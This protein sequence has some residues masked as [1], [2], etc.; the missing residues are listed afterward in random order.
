MIMREWL[1]RARLAWDETRHTALRAMRTTAPAAAPNAI[2]LE[3]RVLLSASP[4]PVVVDG[5]VADTDGTSDLLAPTN[6]DVE[7]AAVSSTDLA[8]PDDPRTAADGLALLD[9]LLGDV[10]RA[11][12]QDGLLCETVSVDSS[13]ADV[14]TG[15]SVV[16]PTDAPPSTPP[17]TDPLLQFT[18]Q[19]HVLGFGQSSIVVASPSHMLQVELVGA[20]LVDPVAVDPTVD[21]AAPG[22]AQPFSGVLYAGVWDGVSAVYDA[23]EGAILKSTYYVDAGLDGSPADQIRLHY[24]RTVSMDGQGNLVIAYDTGT[25]TDSA[26]V[27]WQDIGGQRRFVQV[28]YVLLGN[29]DVGFALGEYDHSEQLVI[30]PS[31]T[32]HTFLGGSGT[33]NGY[34]MAVDGSGNV[35]VTGDSSASW[36]SPVR[37][38][39]TSSDAFVAKLDGNGNLVWNTFLGG[40]GS[41]T[42]RSIAVDESGNVYVG[43]DSTATWGSP[44]R[45]FTA[46]GGAPDAFAAKLN[47][48]GTL[49]WNTFLGSSSN[50]Y[51]RG[52]A[53]DGSGNVYVTGDSSATWGAPVQAFGGSQ[54]A[55]AVKLDSAGSL[56]WNTF[57]GAAGTDTGLGIAV[58]GSGNVYVAGDSTATWGAPVR[59]YS[60]GND[61]FAAKL[62][63]AGS[64]TWNTFLGGSGSDSATGITVDGTGNVYVAGSGSATWGSPVRSYS[65]SGEDAFAA[66]LNSSGSLTWNTF[67][68][69]SG[70]N[71]S[72][73]GIA[74]DGS[75][76]VYVAGSSDATWGTPWR[77]HSSGQDAFAARLDG[78]GSLT[79]NTFL[80][81][82]GTDLG[83][84]IAVNGSGSVYVAGYST[85]T[86]GSPVQ[87]YSSGIDT[88]AAKIATPLAAIRADSTS[89]TSTSSA[90]SLTWAHT[91]ASGANRAIFV[92]LAIDNLAVSVTG[93]TYGGVAMTQVGRSTGNHAVEIWVLVA[94]TVGTANVVATFS[95]TTAAVGGATSFTGVNQ[96]S[97][98]G[99]F[100]GATGTG[101]VASV[102]VNSGVGEL[103]IDTQYWQGN[104]AGGTVGPGQTLAWWRLNAS[105]IGGTTTESG[106]AS[107]VM[108]AS[109]STSTQW[110]IGAVSIKAAPAASAPLLDNSKSPALAAENEDAGAPSGAVG[111]LVSSLVD[112]AAPA[113]QVDNV[114]DA[115]IGAL[116]GIAVTAADTTNGTWYY[117]TNNGTNWNAL[118]AVAS[119]NAR[120]LAADANTRLY[121]QPNANYSGTLSNAITFHAWDQT[122][123]TNG[124]MGGPIGTWTVK[125]TFGSVSYTNNDGVANW[126][127]GWVET[128]DDGDASTGNV[129]VTG[130]ELSID[131]HDFGSLESI[132]RAVDLSGMTSATLS[133]DF[134]TS[135]GVSPSDAVAV[136]VSSDGGTIWSTLETIAN[137]N[138]AISGTRSYDISAYASA[139]TQIRFRISDLLYADTYNAV[140]E[141]FYLDNVQ[142]QYSVAAF[143]LA[144]DTASLV[145]NAVNDAPVLDNT[146]TMTLTSITEDE[147]DN[148]G[149]SVASIIASAGGDRI[150]DVDSGAVEGIAI[151]GLTGNGTWQYSTDG[152]TWTG[153][154]AVSPINALLVAADT[155][156]RYVPDGIAGETSTFSFVAWD[157]TTG[158][159]STNATPSYANPGTGGGT[160]AYSSASSSASITVT[161]INDA[162]IITSNGGGA[163]AS[164]SLAENT[165]TVTTVTSTDVD[166]GTPVYSIVGGADA[167]KFSINGASGVLSFA[168]APDRESPTDVG[169]N[170]VYD[171]T[172]QVSDGNGGT[173]TQDIAVTI[174]DVD[175]FDVG[176]VTDTNGAANAVNENAVNG[177]T[178]GVAASAADAD[179]TNNTIT[180]SLDDNASGRFAIDSNT[181]VVTVAGAI[182]RE[183]AASYSITVRATSADSSYSTQ[184]FTVNV[185]DVDEFDVGAVTDTNGAAN[186][187]NENAVNGT[188]VGVT[189]SASDADATTNTITYSLQNNDGGRFA[190]DTNT[191]VVS[192]AGAIDREADGASRNITV[193][194]TSSDGSFAEQVFTININDLDEFN[195][196]AVVDGDAVANAVDENAT[197]GTLVNI[198]A[199]ASDADATNNTITYSL[200]NNDGGRFAI[201]TNTGVVTVAGAIDR[202]ADGAS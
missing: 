139:G 120:L 127:A 103:V 124:G 17:L 143:S 171:V 125:D 95:G 172:V 38:F 92:E 9:S 76:N 24:N 5:T 130:G 177:T 117:S 52:I 132:A 91:I 153:F 104:P 118:G 12:E 174:T 88:F 32:W 164:I 71:D 160:T 58:D 23:H 115:D 14:D 180:Y 161:S 35:Y 79:W 26:P 6:A 182:D 109:F 51:G 39:D 75:G 42:G 179:A 169:G 70:L 83:T 187:V 107:V 90:T 108:S 198:T 188:T 154:G 30:D 159:A 16:S 21:A 48:S 1:V 196:G 11:A 110:V 10:L 15:D 78:N 55:F 64:L 62:N 135:F 53:A 137:I 36:G 190:I 69:G 31:L 192:V 185:N 147:T 13:V 129:L 65:G 19:G 189:A 184:S 106:A 186:A 116:L 202:E 101:T 165:A 73:R 87:N 27:A 100:A 173:D 144:S 40:G 148:S 158:T 155:R 41:D 142:V 66:K 119:N 77:V 122:S 112:F 54:D 197:Y 4:G 97:P 89:S 102:T 56:T 99:T 168:A 113:G 140:D 114:T 98:T 84:A 68:G 156:V 178:V 146:G 22:A 44:V 3:D 194:A 85:A 105:M 111:T 134:R 195:V 141:F 176:A 150:T 199:A 8:A 50:D 152:V 181:G 2:Q 7:Q 43:G 86:W 121:F 201:D 94:P 63:S 18:S 131:N 151:T 45:A 145:I 34:A 163:A 60:S 37:A 82:S 67:L 136:E 80:G 81:G 200:Q 183:T 72:G 46:G 25:L 170:N 123:G 47:D 157:Q 20:N 33:D 93:V 128:D 29:N 57:L 175:E 61:G 28:S 133:F 191:G 74:V 162:P 96:S 138:G 193:R 166:G 59:A 49:T 126:A 167:A 149:N